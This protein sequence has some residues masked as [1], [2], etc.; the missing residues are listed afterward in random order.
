MARKEKKYHFIY[1][2]TNILSGK[3]YIGMHSTDDLEDGYLG[4]GTRLRY[5]INKYGK[6]N[7]KREI[8][9]FCKSREELKKR[10]SEVINL[11]ELAKINCINLKVGGIGGFSSKEHKIKFIT[12]GVK[13]GRKKTDEILKNRFGD[14]ENWLSKFNSEINKIAWTNEEYRKNKLKNLDW[15][16]KKHLEETKLKISEKLKGRGVGKENSQYGTCW[17]TKDDTTKKIKKEELDI[18][19]KEGWVKGRKKNKKKIKNLHI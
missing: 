1:K 6:E 15:N 7:F 14:D 17:V 16:G 2:T 3:Y 13:T 4:S 8:L 11:N 10:E 12:E 18:Y 19:F 9:E 5:S